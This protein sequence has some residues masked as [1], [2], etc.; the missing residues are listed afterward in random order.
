MNKADFVELKQTKTG[1]S[2]NYSHRSA[3]AF[4]VVVSLSLVENQPYS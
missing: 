2:S 1:S 3:F 4:P